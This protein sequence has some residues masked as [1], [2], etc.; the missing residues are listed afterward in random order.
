[1]GSKHERLGAAAL[2]A[3]VATAALVGIAAWLGS[4]QAAIAPPAPAAQVSEVTGPVYAELVL[5]E[6]QLEPGEGKETVQTF[7]TICHSL[8]PILQHREFPKQTWVAEVDK[9]RQRYGLPINDE[10]AREIVTYLEEH[11][12]LESIQ[13]RARVAGEPV[14]R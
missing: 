9:M 3:G 13:A 11:Y 7:C 10:I 14:A 2:V 1:M 5:A 6:W 4:R 8:A 12:S